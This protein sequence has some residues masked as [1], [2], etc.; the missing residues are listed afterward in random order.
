MKKVNVSKDIVEKL[1]EVFQDLKGEYKNGTDEKVRNRFLAL[2]HYYCDELA[3]SVSRQRDI[4]MVPHYWD[5][6][7]ISVDMSDTP[8]QTMIEILALLDI[9]VTE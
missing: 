9:G 8:L 1:V 5:I 6:A 4:S 7:N 3:E 2:A